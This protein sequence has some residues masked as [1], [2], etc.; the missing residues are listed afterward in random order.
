MLPHPTVLDALEAAYRPCPAFTNVCRSMQWA[1]HAGHVPRGFAGAFG[2]PGEVRLVLVTAEPG[3]PYPWESYPTGP[4][5]R[6]SLEVACRHV[7]TVLE[8][9]H[10]L[11]HRNLRYILAGC[12]PGDS[13]RA[14][15][16][17]AWITDSVLCSAK[18]EGGGVPA[19]V[20]RECRE[21]YLETQLRLF[22][23]AVVVALGSKAVY[24]L[25]GWPSVQPAYSVAPPGCNRK[26]AR[27]TWDAIIE[28]VRAGGPTSRWC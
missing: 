21:R 28:R 13:F 6:D 10:D 7:F 26:G 4:T 14:Q 22:P 20:G 5:S 8:A 3:D 16:E 11:Y 9:G 18:R 1:P 23:N 15:L 24:R 12:F 27:P 25:R 17:R 19:T 2:P